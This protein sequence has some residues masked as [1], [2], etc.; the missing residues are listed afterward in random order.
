MSMKVKELMNEPTAIVGATHTL[1]QA[2][3]RMMQHNAGA[4]VV[5]D[6]S[7]QGPA[8]IAERHITRAIA[9][10]LDVDIERVEDHMRADLVVAAPDWPVRDAGVL[11]VKRG[12]RHV[13]VFDN[14]ELIGVLSMRDVVRAL[15]FEA[16]PVESATG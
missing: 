14:G 15:G 9:Q 10:G 1:R 2:A 5:L 6:P 16:A 13:L 3:S 12:V 7:L 4:A 11:M 8:I